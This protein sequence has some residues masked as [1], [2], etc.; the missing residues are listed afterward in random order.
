MG[1]HT[2]V[3]DDSYRRYAD[4]LLRHSRLLA[5]RG[6]EDAEAEAV[7]EEMTRLWDHLDAVQRRS[8]SGLGSDLNWAHNGCQ[9]APRSRRPEDV[10]PQDLQAIGEAME[11][12][13]WHRVL[14]HL[15]AC[16]P[17]IPPFELARTRALAWRA[18]GFPQ[19]TGLFFDLASELDPSN[20]PIAYAALDTAAQVDLPAALGRARAIVNDPF[21]HPTEVVALAFRILLGVDEG[22]GPRI[23]PEE[24]N[25]LLRAFIERLRLESPSDAERAEI[26]HLAAVSFH[27]LGNF[28]EARSAYEE[29][30]RINPD[31]PAVLVGLGLLLYGREDEKAAGLFARAAELQS[32]LVQPY[33]FLAHY[34]ISRHNFVAALTSCSQALARAASSQVRAQLLE[35]A[36]ICESELSFPDEAVKVL[37]REA[38]ELD[39]ANERISRNQQSFEVGRQ[40]TAGRPYDFEPADSF[41]VRREAEILTALL[42][43]AA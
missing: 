30:L 13:D 18:I 27:L 36:A 21:R 9:L 43:P 5:E 25:E 12:D 17:G 15:R 32:P 40:G 14:H 28:P 33:L 22:D 41:K 8:L 23:D 11:H 24:A 39:P 42:R 2:P 31:D 20:G 16:S 4:L 7:E 1:P 29:V 3:I 37:F 10:T 19:L 34:H 6:D 26:Y 38:R 35:W